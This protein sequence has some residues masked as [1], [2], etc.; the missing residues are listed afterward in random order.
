MRQMIA[1]WSMVMVHG[2]MVAGL[3]LVPKSTRCCGRKTYDPP[4]ERGPSAP[5]PSIVYENWAG[6]DIMYQLDGKRRCQSLVYF[7]EP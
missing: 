1:S 5:V 6:V 7:G 2:L 3:S 4:S